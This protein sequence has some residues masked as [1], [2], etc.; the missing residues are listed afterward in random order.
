MVDVHEAP[1]GSPRSTRH[2]VLADHKALAVS[3]TVGLQFLQLTRGSF[4]VHYR[5]RAGGDAVTVLPSLDSEDQDLCCEKTLVI[6]GH[7]PIPQRV[8]SRSMAVTRRM[9]HRP[10]SPFD[11]Y[12]CD[13]GVRPRGN[14]TVD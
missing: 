12:L 13:L 7:S 2:A 1:D 9:A 6:S 10:V 3:V 5:K 11:R 14:R 4:P 8:F